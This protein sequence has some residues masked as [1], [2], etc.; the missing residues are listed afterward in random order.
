[1]AQMLVRME[2]DGLIRRAP[3]P[4]DGRSSLVSLTE[5]GGGSAA[6]TRARCCSKAIAR[7]VG[8]VPVGAEFNFRLRAASIPSCVS[9]V[10][11]AEERARD[12]L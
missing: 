12:G 10:S 8:R 1:M 9:L 3:D 11:D 6:G 2:R 4:A 5:V 7:R